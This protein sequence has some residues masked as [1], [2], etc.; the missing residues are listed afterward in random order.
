M[1]LLGVLCMGMMVWGLRHRD[2]D[3]MDEPEN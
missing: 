2:E 1:W 3:P